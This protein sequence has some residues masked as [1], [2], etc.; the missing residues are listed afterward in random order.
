MKIIDKSLLALFAAAFLAAALPVYAFDYG[1]ARINSRD[2]DDGQTALLGAAYNAYA[3]ADWQ[4]AVMLFRKAL[5]DPQNES[6]SALYMLVMAEMQ[7]KS[8]K[9]ALSDSAYFLKNY[10]RSSYAPLISYQQGRCL[11]YLGEFDKAVLVLSDFC[12]QNP[13]NDMYAAALFWI[14][15]SF[16][17]GYN[18]EQARPLYERVV[19]E[20]PKD[21]KAVD[22]KY[23][24]DSINQRLRE[25]KLLYLLQQTGESYLSSKESYEKALRRYELEDALRGSLPQESAEMEKAVETVLND[26]AVTPVSKETTI[27]ASPA[28]QAFESALERLK[29][30]AA[31]AQALLDQN[32]GAK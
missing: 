19:D 13:H 29:R 2:M 16:Y 30:S 11:Y 22:A 25:E 17:S 6:D 7:S 32:G 15:E 9:A 10:Q 21:A 12:H 23:R 31:E 3:Q 5:S 1:A 28:D 26:E 14:A 20:F 24:L 18:F 27:S 8:Y 4:S